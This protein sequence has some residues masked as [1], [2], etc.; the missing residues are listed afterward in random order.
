MK[1]G[2]IVRHVSY[3]ESRGLIVEM[4][5]HKICKVDWYRGK[6]KRKMRITT[7]VLVEVSEA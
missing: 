5:N 1:T 4:E 3:P 2:D 7:D 6:F